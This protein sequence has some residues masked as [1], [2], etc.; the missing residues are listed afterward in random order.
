MAKNST[1]YL[2]FSLS[3]TDTSRTMAIMKRILM[4]KLMHCLPVMLLSFAILAGCSSNDKPKVPDEPLDVLYKQAQSQLHDGDYN[5]ATATLEAIDSRY[6]FGPYASQVQL[7][8][9]YAYYK[10]DDSAQ[11]IA[12]IDRF[13]RL[14]P[15]NRNIDYVYYMR[16][17]ANMQQDYNF[18]QNFFG[19]DR[20]DRDPS[21]SRQAFRDFQ[22]LLKNYP[23]SVYASDARTRAIYLKNQLAKY[24]L[25]VADFY[26]RREAWLSAANRA[27]DLITNYPDTEMTKPA[28]EIM[29]QAYDK[30]NLTDLANHA[31]Q[32]QAANYHVDTV[33]TPQ[34]A[35]TVTDSSFIDKLKFWE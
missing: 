20:S 18:F 10:K 17:L 13:I 7:E 9:I 30:M 29:V 16:G 26:M 14:N 27:K 15:T 8:L 28:L 12:N 1:F 32:M 31:R 2:F 25:A 11:A 22:L 35:A 3:I 34:P 6:P 23:N 24:D 21:F 4:Q 33:V 5:N 19:I